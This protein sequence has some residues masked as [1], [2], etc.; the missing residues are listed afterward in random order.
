MKIHPQR[1]PVR[2]VSLRPDSGHWT[3]EKLPYVA[4]KRLFEAFATCVGLIRVVLKALEALV[5]F[6]SAYA[7]SK[8]IENS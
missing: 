5:R 2:K 3:I 7:F 8:H 6:K 1:L 4:R